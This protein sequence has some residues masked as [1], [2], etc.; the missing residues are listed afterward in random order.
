[1]QKS[2]GNENDM[3]L[4]GKYVIQAEGTSREASPEVEDCTAV[5]KSATKS[6][7]MQ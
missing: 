3:Q 5:Q 4:T 7:C 1:M 6:L 2:K